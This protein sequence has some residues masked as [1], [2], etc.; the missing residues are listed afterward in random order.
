MNDRKY[1]INIYNKEKNTKLISIR[2]P[3]STIKE[4]DEVYLHDNGIKFIPISKSNEKYIF[5][6]ALIKIN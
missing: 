6:Y 1:N 5:Y 4:I 2:I 3:K